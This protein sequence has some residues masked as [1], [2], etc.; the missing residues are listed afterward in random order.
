MTLFSINLPLAAQDLLDLFVLCLNLE[1]F[2]IPVTTW[3]IN[4]PAINSQAE[5]GKV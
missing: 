1:V 4:F 3:N 5:N 2:K